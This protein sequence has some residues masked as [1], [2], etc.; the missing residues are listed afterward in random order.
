MSL[1]HHQGVRRRKMR[2]RETTT[3]RET[4]RGVVGNLS[5]R[6]GQVGVT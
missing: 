6:S 1:S 2:K 3:M 4:K 5:R